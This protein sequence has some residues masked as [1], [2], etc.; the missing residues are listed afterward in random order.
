MSRRNRIDRLTHK[1]GLPTCPRCGFPLP[2]EA[3][4]RVE[5]LT[6]EELDRRIAELEE[7]LRE[8]RPAPG[9]VPNRAPS[10][11]GEP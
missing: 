10:E 2:R 5:D 11:E 8:P 1:A 3:G 7:E 4:E 6:D 9:P